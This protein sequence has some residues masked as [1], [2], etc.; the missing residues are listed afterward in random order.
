MNIEF[1]LIKN[2]FQRNSFPGLPSLMSIS[3]QQQ[4]QFPAAPSESG[5]DQESGCSASKLLRLTDTLAL[6][7]EARHRLAD[8]HFR[9]FVA[10][11][12]ELERHM[13]GSG[14]TRVA[15]PA[16]GKGPSSKSPHFVF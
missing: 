3:Q 5:G 14:G 4:K 2:K 6:A 8:P 1:F 9:H 11:V 13:L 16:A 12:G 15:T 7:P 10:I